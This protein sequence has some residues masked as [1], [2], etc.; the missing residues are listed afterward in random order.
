MKMEINDED[1]GEEQEE[2]VQME[3][4][5]KEEQGGVG[6]EGEERGREAVKGVE[7]FGKAVD[8]AQE[9]LKCKT[10][11]GFAKDKHG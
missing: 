7:D 1:K 10:K 8:D 5:V 11:D 6:A 9:K 4:E 3:K 2:E